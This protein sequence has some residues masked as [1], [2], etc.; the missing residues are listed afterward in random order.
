M[1]K[2]P[3]FDVIFRKKPALMLLTLYLDEK[4]RYGSALAKKID[5]TYSHAVKVLKNLEKMKLIV[6]EKKG[7]TKLVTLTN[8]GKQVAEAIKKIKDIID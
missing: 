2:T 7:R 8:Q 4:A 1:A 6:F 5:C 3:G